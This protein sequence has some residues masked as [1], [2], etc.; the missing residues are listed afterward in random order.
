MN[1]EELKHSV[2]MWEME[3]AMM[4]QNEVPEEML[5]MYEELDPLI[6]DG[7][8]SYEEFANDTMKY[9]AKFAGKKKRPMKVLKEMHKHLIDKYNARRKEK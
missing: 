4:S 7:I 2:T 6:K 8:V 5:T 1:E 3:R 9:L